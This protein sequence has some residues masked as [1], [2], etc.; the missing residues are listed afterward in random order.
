[1][2]IIFLSF[3]C[4]IVAILIYLLVAPFYLEI[5]STQ[6]LYRFRFH[7]LASVSFVMDEYPFLLVKIAGW[8]KEITIAGKRDASGAVAKEKEP[9]S[10]SRKR[11]GLSYHQVKQVLKSFK[12]RAFYLDIDFDDM[13]LNGMLFPCFQWLSWYSGKTFKINFNGNRVLIVVVKNSIARM[14]WALISSKFKNHPS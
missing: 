11:N 1:M 14:S 4:A 9:V 12:V 5:D 7:K 2:A 10:P 6:G 8:K 13:P 3:I